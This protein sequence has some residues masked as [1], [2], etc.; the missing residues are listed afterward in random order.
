MTYSII[1]FPILKKTDSVGVMAFY[2]IAY[3]DRSNTIRMN[4]KTNEKPKY[5]MIIAKNQPDFLISQNFSINGKN[6]RS[7]LLTN[8]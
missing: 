3:I 6:R 4:Y 5:K 7:G 1:S 2:Y 8:H